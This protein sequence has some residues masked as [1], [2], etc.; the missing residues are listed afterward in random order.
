M[1]HGFHAHGV[2]LHG[3]EGSHVA[4]L[5][6]HVYP[7]FKGGHPHFKGPLGA[8]ELWE[9]GVVTLGALFG[10]TTRGREY[11]AGAL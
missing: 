11:E 10:G 8:G 6:G 4:G 2:R 5:I 7:T 3:D 9:Q 1:K